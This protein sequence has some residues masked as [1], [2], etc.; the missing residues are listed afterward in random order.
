M[1]LRRL[2]YLLATSLLAATPLSAQ[3]NSENVRA[4]NG[5]VLQFEAALQRAAAAQSG[6]IRA[7]AAPVFAQ[8]AA[9]LTALIRENPAAALGLAFSQD[10]RDQ[11]A[12]NFPASAS[13][14]EQHGAW[15]GTSFQGFLRLR[16]LA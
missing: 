13:S 15:T 1:A 6:Q 9:A 16:S 8:R 7:D 2:S 14:L 3:G 12:G 4:L 10:L 11:L 5:R